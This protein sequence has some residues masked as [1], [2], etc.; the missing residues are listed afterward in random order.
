MLE[1]IPW[2]FRWMLSSEGSDIGKVPN[3]CELHVFT[4]VHR[5][6]YIFVLRHFFHLFR[7]KDFKANLFVLF[8]RWNISPSF[9]VG[10]RSTTV[11]LAIIPY[12]LSSLHHS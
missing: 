2:F 12:H 3:I 4:Q 1:H 11:H 7:T 9:P 10:N 6:D 5:T 8:A